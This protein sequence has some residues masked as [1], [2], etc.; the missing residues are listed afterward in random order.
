MSG[1]DPLSNFKS[2]GALEVEENL[3]PPQLVTVPIDR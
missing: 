2:T 1:T 3:R